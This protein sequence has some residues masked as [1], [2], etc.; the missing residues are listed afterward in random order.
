MEDSDAEAGDGGGEDGKASG[1][2]CCENREPRPPMAAEIGGVGGGEQWQGEH[3][4]RSTPLW[5]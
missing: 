1:G 5:V 2:G 4:G 3:G